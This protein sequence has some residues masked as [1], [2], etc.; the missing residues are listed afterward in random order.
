MNYNAVPENASM[1]LEALNQMENTLNEI[2]SG[3]SFMT[4]ADTGTDVELVDCLL[5][6]LAGYKETLD[7]RRSASKKA[8]QGETDDIQKQGIKEALAWVES[9][10]ALLQ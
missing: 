3:D 1:A 2:L 5:Q 7:A 8:M 10:K 4:Y 6:D 9:V